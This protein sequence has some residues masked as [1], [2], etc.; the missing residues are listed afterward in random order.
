[1][2][3]RGLNIGVVDQKG[4]ALRTFS[5]GVVQPIAFVRKIP[6]YFSYL[7]SRCCGPVEGNQTA[8]AKGHAGIGVTQSFDLHHGLPISI[9]GVD[10][11]KLL[12]WVFGQRYE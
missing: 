12:L 9:E 5:L 6:D 1:M 11:P 2:S 10:L 4:V 8:A 7:N 3:R